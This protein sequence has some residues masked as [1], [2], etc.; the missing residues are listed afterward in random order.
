MGCLLYDYVQT[1]PG[2]AILRALTQS[3]GQDHATDNWFH[4]MYTWYVSIQSTKPLIVASALT[5]WK[6]LYADP[7]ISNLG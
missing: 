7:V 6:L 4:M 5:I 1:Y 3:V 2:K